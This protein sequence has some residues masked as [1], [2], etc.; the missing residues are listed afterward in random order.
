[1]RAGAS[2]LLVLTLLA[3]GTAPRP[4]LPSD[5]LVT[6]LGVDHVDVTTRFEGESI[7]VFG[8]VPPGSDV[9]IRM[10]SPEQELDL[11]RKVQLGPVW[12]EDGHLDLNGVPGLVYLLST[13]PLERLLDE[14]DR[15]A[16]GL[17]LGSP[18]ASAGI[19][20]D[21]A[22]EP[23]APSD[24]RAALLRLK[25]LR[26]S[27]LED[28]QGVGLDDGRLFHARLDLPAESPLGLYRVSVY[29]VRDGE[30]VRRQEK[31]LVVQA[32]RLQHWLGHVAHAYP[33]TFGSLLTLGLLLLGLALGMVL[34]PPD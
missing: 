31:T 20:G 29:L 13:R 7:L 27:Y 4:A 30:V 5:H 2:L 17:T 25:R 15:T 22:G 8:A 26:G 19:A 21:R 3:A 33:W 24:W 28:G 16:L 6:R 9:V 23:S 10:V 11:S 34:R 18:L 1:M 14:S 32:V 12:L